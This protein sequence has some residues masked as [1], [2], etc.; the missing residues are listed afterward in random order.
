MDINKELTE[1][2]LNFIE[3]ICERIGPQYSYSVQAREA[4]E[5]IKKE[6]L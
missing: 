2:M 3:E 5:T 1:Y 4:N 6:F